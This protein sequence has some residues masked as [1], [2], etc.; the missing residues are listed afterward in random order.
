[1]TSHEKHSNTGPLEESGGVIGYCVKHM[2]KLYFRPTFY[3]SGNALV[4]L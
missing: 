2:G 1:M 3:Q 4:E